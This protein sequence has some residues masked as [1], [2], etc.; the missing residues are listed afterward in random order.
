MRPHARPRARR[1]PARRDD[2]ALP[3]DPRG[4]AHAGRADR[5]AAG[6]PESRRRGALRARRPRSRGRRRCAAR[7]RR[8]GPTGRL[9]RDRRRGRDRQDPALR[10]ARV[11]RAR[12]RRP[13]S[14]VRCFQE[15]AGLAYGVVMQLVR[16]AAGRRR[17]APHDG[18]LV[19]P[20]RPHGSLPELGAPP[21]HA[22][23]QPGGPGAL[24]R[25]GLRARHAQC[26]APGSR[27]RRASTTSTG[28]TRR[29]SACS[30]TSRTASAAARSCSPLSVAARGG[31]RPPTRSGGFSPTPQRTGARPGCS[32]SAGSH[33]RDVGA[34]V[35][36]RGRTSDLASRLHR[37]SGG[38]PFFVVEYLDALA[39]GEDRTGRLADAGRRA[40]AP[41]SAASPRSASS[42]GQVA[43]RRRG[44]GAVVRPGH[45][46]RRERPHRRG[47]RHRARG[48][49]RAR[50]AAS[51]RATARSTSATSR[52]AISSTAR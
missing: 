17:T 8:S 42:R 52:R 2:G 44:A 45:R 27:R 47:D 13:R 23:R 39:R 33:R 29:R 19:A 38:L 6:T 49:R 32:L 48:A 21:P 22:P 14:T 5:A 10:R 31:S 28:P 36:R 7:S 9:A 3:R 12:A 15:E 18:R 34:L 30:A 4:C 35:R 26:V 1:P 11:A 37:E 51:R 43:R 46:P 40:R 25:G 41:R 24:L 50:P 20:P 16:A